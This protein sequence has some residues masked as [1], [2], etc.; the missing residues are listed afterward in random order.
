MLMSISQWFMFPKKQVVIHRAK[1]W[2]R[3][4]QVVLKI[5]LSSSPPTS[6]S[7]SG[8]IQG[9][10]YR[11]WR[12]SGAYSNW[13]L[14]KMWQNIP[15]NHWF[16]CNV[17][18]TSRVIQLFI[19]YYLGFWWEGF[20]LFW[21]ANCHHFSTSFMVTDQISKPFAFHLFSLDYA[22]VYL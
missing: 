3:L 10:A 16:F 4:W 13:H 21:K 17:F 12:T 22:V 15:S 5:A 9:L 1:P 14:K 11:N 20:P 8:F 18:G 19:Q 6:C 2:L 7:L